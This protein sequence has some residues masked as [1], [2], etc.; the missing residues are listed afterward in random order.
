[1]GLPVEEE[2][3]LARLR[4][5]MQGYGAGLDD[6]GLAQAQSQDALTRG[7]DRASDALHAAFTNQPV[8][9]Q[10]RNP[11]MADA[12]VQRRAGIDRERAAGSQQEKA[13]RE[14]EARD[15]N[16]EM[17]RA[18]REMFLASPVG[19]D[20]VA[21]MGG[22]KYFDRMTASQLPAGND[23]M[24][25]FEKRRASSE[26]ERV[27]QEQLREQVKAKAE[28]EATEAQRRQ[29]E[30]DGE[31]GFTSARDDAERKFRA[32]ESLKDRVSR[33]R[34]AALSAGAKAAK[35][36]APESGTTISGMDIIP[37]ADPTKDDAKKVKASLAAASRM[38]KYVDE[39]AALH[40]EH[41]T[42]LYGDVATRMSQLNEA[43]TLEAKNIGELGALSGPDEEIVKRLKGVDPTSI[44]S[45]T[46]AL[47]GQDNTQTAL[48]GLRKWT[49]DALEGNKET[50]GYK[51]KAGPPSRGPSTV[52]IKFPN[53]KVVQVPESDVEEALSH[54]GVR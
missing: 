13:R 51:S 49:D 42:E 14:A 17:N 46:K 20:F 26:A 11:G 35:D 10:D 6:A 53:G 12:I 36:A 48:E 50:Y 34:A 5:E 43:I 2:S 28:A 15:P 24:N 23:Y 45:N 39:L 7:A 31:H 21:D 1:M 4:R 54:G 19:K 29:R 44:W 25:A 16:S 47:V 3:E 40:K 38:R 37:G 22:P 27:R 30:R 41:G 52:P 32:N 18:A 8:K 33:E 9:F